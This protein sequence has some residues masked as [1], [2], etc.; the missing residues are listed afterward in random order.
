MKENNFLLFRVFIL[1]YALIFLHNNK[2]TKL[3]FNKL[4]DKI[5]HSQVI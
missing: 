5:F 4:V 3:T 2:L 1:K